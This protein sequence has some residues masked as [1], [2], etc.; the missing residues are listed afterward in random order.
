MAQAR[1]TL[2]VA[3]LDL[4]AALDSIP[5]GRSRDREARDGTGGRDG[6]GGGPGHR[7]R[8]EE[9][10]GAPVG[11]P[12]SGKA[13]RVAAVARA[14]V[15]RAAVARCRFP[16]ELAPVAIRDVE[17]VVSAVGSVEAFEQ[18]QI[19]ARVAGVVERVGFT[20]GQVVKKGEVLA[21][22]E[23]T[24]YSLAVDAAKAALEKAQATASE[25][26]AGAQRRAAV[27]EQ[28]PGLL[29]AE[30]LETFQTRAAHRGGRGE[31]G[32]GGA[33]S[34]PAE[35]AGRVRESAHG[36]GAADAHHPDGPVRAAGLRA[37]H[38]AA[39]RSVAGA[40]PRGRGRRGAHQAGHGSAVL[41]ARGQPHLQREDHPRGGRGGRSEPHGAGDGGGL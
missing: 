4:R 21:E 31:R 27:N 41:G 29:P 12:P 34:G 24:R 20:E 26:Q 13:A 15:A 30:E 11:G 40:L 8:Q 33:G 38:A 5:W 22:I 25:A 17:Y 14:A 6:R 9:G 16:V 28:R 19:T 3:L 2:G 23:P 36:R 35:P 18:V 37:G 7:V 1:Y 32:E 10:E 39:P